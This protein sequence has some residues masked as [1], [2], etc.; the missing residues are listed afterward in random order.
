[1]TEVQKLLDKGFISEDF[2]KEEVRDEYRIS[3]TLKKTWAIQMDLLTKLLEVCSRHGL[4]VWV[5]GGSLLGAVRHHGFIPWDD[6]IDVI[7]PRTDYDKL[8]ELTSEFEHPYCLSTPFSDE[9]E[10]YFPTARL[11]N[12]NTYLNHNVSKLEDIKWNSG[13]FIDI[14][15]LEGVPSSMKALRR[16][17]N[18]IKAYTVALHSYVLNINA[19]WIA[20]L[21]HKVLHFPLLGLTSQK[22]CRKMHNIARK[23]EFGNSDKVVSLIAT[24]YSVEHNI[25]DT[26]DWEETIWLPFENLKVPVPKGY[27]G[28]LKVSFGDYMKLP[29]VEKRGIWHHF[30]VDPDTP[31][32][33]VIKEGRY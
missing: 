4:R 15:I 28:V 18:T 2:L 10:I 3:T 7:M 13:I 11:C 26:S 24:P 12:S 9:G 25:F 14:F 31:Y 32:E 5:V 19:H 1:M 30:T 8:M 33:E 6:D 23:S 29:P 17:F 27:D 22:I 20:R 21:L 16:R